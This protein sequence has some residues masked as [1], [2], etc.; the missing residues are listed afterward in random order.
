MT[1]DFYRH[2][3]QVS[4]YLWAE[5]SKMI[6]AARERGDATEREIADAVLSAKRAGVSWSIITSALRLSNK[7]A[8][9]CCEPGLK[10]PSA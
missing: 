8:R 2:P 9:E 10:R 3:S 6:A 7:A 5:H 4:L 1:H